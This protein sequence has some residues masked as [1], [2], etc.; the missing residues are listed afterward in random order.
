MV[1]R[2]EKKP[3]PLVFSVLVVVAFFNLDRLCY[4]FGCVEINF[5]Y[6]PFNGQ[7]YVRQGMV[8]FC[9]FFSSILWIQLLGIVGSIRDDVLS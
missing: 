6:C 3:L 9:G 7:F 2:H 4:L 8:Y 5:F 1:M